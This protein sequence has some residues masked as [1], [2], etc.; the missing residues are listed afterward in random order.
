MLIEKDSNISYD[1]NGM[2]DFVITLWASTL[3]LSLLLSAIVKFELS[4]FGRI[5]IIESTILYFLS[6]TRRYRTGSFFHHH[7]LFMKGTLA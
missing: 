6:L 1:S 5:K 4:F 3:L 2:R 7:Y